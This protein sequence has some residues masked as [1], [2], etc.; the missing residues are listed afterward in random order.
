MNVVVFN[1]ERQ[2][3]D[4]LMY[5]VTV[6]FD[7]SP[8]VKYQA[9]YDD[10]DSRARFCNVEPDLFMELSNLAHKR[11]GDCTIYQMELMSIIGAFAADDLDLTL[12]AQLGTTQ[13]CWSKP[14][15]LKILRNKLSYWFT[16]IKWRLG[17][18]RP[19]LNDVT[20]TENAG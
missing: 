8:P 6:S 14:T 1:I 20:G 10:S 9:S 19:K 17:I 5:S 12:P 2:L 16:M 11:F 15:H 13:Y 7:D 18:G 4:P 3:D